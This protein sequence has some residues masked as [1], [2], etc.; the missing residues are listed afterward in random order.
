MNDRFDHHLVHGL[1][2]V[3]LL[4][5]TVVSSAADSASEE[6]MVTRVTE[7]LA[8]AE[9]EGASGI[10]RITRNGAVLFESGF[11]SASCDSLEDIT[12]AHLFMIGSI[13]KEMTKVL[14][15]VLE[16][17]GLL[18]FDKTVSDYLPGFGG[19]VGKVSVD[20]LLHHTGGVPDL[21]DE[22]GRPVPYSID[23][24][25]MPV[26]RDELLERAE[27][28]RLVFEPG[29]REEY[30]NLGYQL[31]AA[32]YEEITGET[33]QALLQR[34]IFEPAGMED[35][36]YWFEDAADRHFVDGC[37]AGDVHWGNPIEDSM[38]DSSGPSWNLIGAG[39]LLST[40]GSLGRFFEGIGD[41]VYF[42]STSQSERFKDDR[43]V[44][45]ETREQRVMGSAG[46]NGIF[47]AAAFWAERSRFNVILITNRADHQGEAR[48]FRDIVRI[49]PP[50]YF[51]ASDQQ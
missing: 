36:G 43:M 17:R 28:A 8:A 14:G 19:Q 24:D 37:R 3:A 41:G 40:A 25:Y 9:G 23:Y 39:G 32:I 1:A 29:E 48:L 49:F 10:L 30:S 16:E 35:T 45:S 34:Y 21:I 26:A 46:S 18:S 5:S 6:Q 38:W 22:A 11:G 15:F 13:T 2:V 47:N 51:L 12:P 31:L 4:A 50:S 44:Y 7:R 33:F 42:Q 27:R 20:R